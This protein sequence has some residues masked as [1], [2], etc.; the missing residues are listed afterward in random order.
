[1]KWTPRHVLTHLLESRQHAFCKLT[2]P[3]AAKSSEII[4]PQRCPVQQ[5]RIR[6]KYR[7]RRTIFSTFSSTFTM[8]H[9]TPQNVD[10]NAHQK[11][12][13][14]LILAWRLQQVVAKLSNANSTSGT[15][16]EPQRHYEIASQPWSRWNILF[17]SMELLTFSIRSP[18]VNTQDENM[19][20]CKCA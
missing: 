16:C 12:V 5:R 15:K 11:N 13:N 4:S 2:F 20:S 6:Y 7:Y 17:F 14:I 3:H 18:N 9:R 10:A 8:R 1:M 19:H